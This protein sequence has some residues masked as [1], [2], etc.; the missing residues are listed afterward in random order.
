[1]KNLR[2]SYA[3]AWSCLACLF[4]IAKIRGSAAN[5]RRLAPPLFWAILILTSATSTRAQKTIWP[6]TAVPATVD[7]GQTGAIELGVSFKADTSGTIS[8]IRFYKSAAN[9]GTHVGHLW[10]STGTLLASVVFSGETPS[11]WQQASLSRPVSITANTVYVASYQSANGHW[12]VNWNSLVNSGVNNPPLHALQNGLGGPN[13]VWG[14]AG[15]FP[16]GTN[17]SNYW[18]DVVFNGLAAPFISTQPKSQSVAVGQTAKFAVG[19]SGASPMSFQWKKNGVA[20]SGATSTS[21][22]IPAVTAADNGDQYT[23]TVSN[24]VGTATSSRAVLAVNASTLTYQIIASPS[25]LSFGSVN[26]GSSSSLP[27]TVKNSGNSNVS[28]SGISISGAG[29]NVGG[30]SNGTTLTPGQTATL[31]VTFAPVATGSVT[32]NVSVSSNATNSPAKVALSG[33]GAISV[34][35]TVSLSWNDSA[36]TVAGFNIYRS[37]TSGNGYVKINSSLV[38]GM[39]YTDSNV[40][41]GTTYFYVTTAVDSSGNESA[42]SNQAAAAIP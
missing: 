19:A 13:G 10:S 17:G 12:S 37:T 38:G 22:K 20:I 28:I 16:N 9:T 26:A 27:V 15:S 3:C 29:F 11:G 36:S 23:V 8:A 32:G 21:Y 30:V 14:V 41:S 35:H 2:S 24:S 18:I 25:S 39:T 42:Y 5:A 7:S 40:T 6:G 1:M 34:Q 33:S 31:N 4:S